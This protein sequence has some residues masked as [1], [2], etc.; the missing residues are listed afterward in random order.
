VRGSSSDSK[1][2]SPRGGWLYQKLFASKE[3]SR[4]GTVDGG[5][6]SPTAAGVGAS[7]GAAQQ[8][9]GVWGQAQ[10]ASGDGAAGAEAP[11]LY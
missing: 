5:R 9:S 7:V 11:C 6:G 3:Q 10:A 4:T 8:G 2:S 1:A